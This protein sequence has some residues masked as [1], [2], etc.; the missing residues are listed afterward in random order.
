M[1]VLLMESEPWAA[2]EA[3]Y[4]LE[5]AGH[6]VE[7]CFGR[8][9]PSFPCAALRE[10]G[11]CPFSSGVDVALVVRSEAWQV[12]MSLERGVVCA[13][14]DGVPLVVAGVLDPDPFTRWE[15][16]SVEGTDQVVAVCERVAATRPARRS[17][18]SGGQIHPTMTADP[19]ATL[20][21]Y[22]QAAWDSLR[23]CCPGASKD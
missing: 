10:G 23:H 22:T 5:L 17:Q 15:T 4:R 20:H 19:A 16:A 11:T 9:I 18:P 2:D 21:R 1:R 6:T 8:N 7:R 13:I 14:R 3:A 12:P